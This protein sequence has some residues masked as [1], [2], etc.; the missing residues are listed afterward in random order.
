MTRH[1]DV[2]ALPAVASVN[3]IALHGADEAMTQDV[4]RQRA[5]TELL[6]QEAT[7]LGLPDA[8]DSAAIEALLEQAVDIPEPSPEACRRY[9]EAN[10]GRFAAGERLRLRHILFAVTQGVD[11]NALRLRAEAL[12]LE[13]R[14]ADPHGDSFATAARRWSNC[15]TGADGGHLG[16]VTRDECAAEFA[17]EV[18]GQ[19]TIG[20]IPRLVHSRFGFHVI[21]V[22]AR[23]AGVQP[24]FEDVGRAVAAVL[25]QQAWARCLR[26]Y[27]QV[28][29]GRADLR[30]VDLQGVDNPLVQ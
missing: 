24:R 14:C 6:R 1:D 5:C 17:R 11:V 30:G 29:A 22:C 3:G 12:L 16:W 19:Q 8:A 4:L 20:I 9:F 21:E 28:L 13:L 2:R 7:R 25:R 23:E 26:Q 10:P 15:P 27:L 18:F